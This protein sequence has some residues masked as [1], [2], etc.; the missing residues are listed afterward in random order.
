[1]LVAELSYDIEVTRAAST[2][3]TVF[4]WSSGITSGDTVTFAYDATTPHISAIAP[5]PAAVISYASG[6]AAEV[7]VASDTGI[8]NVKSI[9]S[10][11]V[12]ITAS[13]PATSRYAAGSITY[14]V[15]VTAIASDLA[16]VDHALNDGAAVMYMGQT[17]DAEA[18]STQ[19][20]AITYETAPTGVVTIS[21]A[22]LITTVATGTTT[23]TARQAA[24]GNYA[25]TTVILNLE[26]KAPASVTLAWSDSD[27][28]AGTVSRTFDV[29]SF[30]S[31]LTVTPQVAGVL[32][33]AGNSGIVAVDAVTGQVN[34]TGTGLGTVTIT[35]TFTPSD[36][37]YAVTTLTYDLTIT[38]GTGNSFE[39]IAD[40]R[41]MGGEVF[42]ARGIGGYGGT[43]TYT[44]D[45]GTY[46]A[47]DVNGTVT[48]V[49][50]TAGVQIA[51]ITLTE[52]KQNYEDLTLTYKVTVIPSVQITG[53]TATLNMYEAIESYE[54][55]AVPAYMDGYITWTVAGL[56]ARDFSTTVEGSNLRIKLPPKGV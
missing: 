51:N 18:T 35:G 36:P 29:G 1:M 48:T 7:D 16:W 32:S 10:S 12:T 31:T 14:L 45:N 43:I 5:D 38:E 15:A 24:S 46:A 25:E 3:D 8:L 44:S 19:G 54:A 20:G 50:D 23:I 13:Y 49:N 41:V 53:I 34:F 55:L 33:Y 30:L 2:P 9:T 6:T 27:A 39:A 56:N 52:S 17:L 40:K 26:V 37:A 21:T 4:K 22:G 28:I 42:T 47:V 11:P